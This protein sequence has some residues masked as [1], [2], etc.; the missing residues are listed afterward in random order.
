MGNILMTS[1]ASKLSKDQ[2]N[3]EENVI[4]AKKV[5]K[6][7]DTYLRSLALGLKP[8]LG[9]ANFVGANVQSFIS[10]S[11]IYG[12]R[13][14]VKN[15]GRVILPFDK[16]IN[17]I[18]RA[19]IDTIV[20]LTGED[21][22]VIKQRLIAEK[23]S[24]ANY[25]STWTFSDVMMTTNSFG[26]KRVELANALS[27]IDNAIVINGR[28]L[29]I[30]QYLKAKDREAKKGMTFEDRRALEKSFDE[31]IKQLKEGD[32]TLKKLSK[33]VNDELVIEG[34]SVEEL[35]KFRM[36]VIDNSRN[37]TGQMSYEDKM[38]FRRDTLFNSFMMFKGWIPKQLSVRYKGITKNTA[39]DE[40]EYGRFRAFFSTLRHIG[41]KN[42]TDLR[43]ITLGTDKGLALI[44]EMLEEK[45]R[46]YFL[47]TGKELKITEEEYQDLI[48]T[49]VNNMYKELALI[50]GII[51]L[52]ITAKI[53]A[54]DDD[55][56][57]LTKNR[58]KYFAKAINK[59]SD[60]LLFYVNPASADEMTKGSIIPSLGL[61]SKVG[62][63]LKALLKEVYYTA[64]DDDKADKT[65]PLKY[66]INLIP[67]G[68]QTL[69]EVLPLIDPELA[70]E[71]GV[72]VT[73]E[74][75]R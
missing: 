28:I 26:E 27:M 33:M 70:K 2:E 20:P 36:A 58:Y 24:Y 21:P 39:T 75:R 50:V 72:R 18:E 52:L 11:G 32:N 46:S 35:A 64:S 61:L 15:V 10:S 63:L 23:K 59:I 25:L 14:F 22:L 40:W 68:S 19:L 69:N 41:I 47:K 13:E 62:S 55:E 60:E 67:I 74:S 43:D 29:N 31:R 38:G 16:G 44:N 8:L 45:K 49:Q 5:L 12:K 73:S 71:M 42:I 6:T 65:Y 37:I 57:D 53:I 17:L 34:V 54:P 51:G 66:F 3:V 48:R 9:V 4:S 30:R 1:T 7:G 56:D